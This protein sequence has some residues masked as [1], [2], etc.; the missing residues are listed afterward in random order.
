M[1][2]LKISSKKKSTK[3]VTNEKD[4]TMVT[5]DAVVAPQDTPKKESSSATVKRK[6]FGLFSKSKSKEQKGTTVSTPPRTANNEENATTP[7]TVPENDA[8]DL[9]TYNVLSVVPFGNGVDQRPKGSTRTEDILQKNRS[10][11][12]QLNTVDT[13]D[14]PDGAGEEGTE[15]I[16]PMPSYEIDE[17]VSEEKIDDEA[18]EIDAN[19]GNET[20]D[21]NRITVVDQ[22]NE[23]N[24]EEDVIDIQ[25]PT[26]TND[27]VDL[28]NG[29]ESAKEN[30]ESESKK[31]GEGDVKSDV[32]DNDNVQSDVQGEDV[33]EY[34]QEAEGFQ[35]GFVASSA[36]RIWTT[37]FGCG[38]LEAADS[39]SALPV[40]LQ[41]DLYK[42]GITRA[43]PVDLNKMFDER[44]GSDFLHVSDSSTR[45]FAH[46]IR[47]LYSVGLVSSLSLG[48]RS[49]S[50][51]SLLCLCWNRSAWMFGIFR[52]PICLLLEHNPQPQPKAHG[53]RRVHIDLSHS[54]R[55]GFL[56]RSNR[57]PGVP[58]RDLQRRTHRPAGH[59]MEHD[60]G[61]QIEFC[62][63]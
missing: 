7:D 33:A 37:T 6:K 48:K 9:S 27:T 34:P 54:G 16:L 24:V 61:G 25:K 20:F 11:L 41:K 58:S 46:T 17:D 21:N 49:L 32:E 52:F 15:L 28:N 18:K 22:S 35:Q 63:V 59:R 57:Q 26:E 19:Q 1:K 40:I 23:E 29:E 36:V 53:Q 38:D 13:H 10:L 62:R 12:A 50:V 14:G 56:G 5:D 44:T 60:G 31:E 30:I 47:R 39:C 55:R 8:Y 43:P 42:S 4:G 2:L 45:L 3:S 51:F